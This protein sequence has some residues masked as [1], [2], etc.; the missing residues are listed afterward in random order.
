M[1]KS[2]NSGR[3]GDRSLVQIQLRR[4]QLRWGPCWYGRAPVKRTDTGSIPVTATRNGRASQWA[5]AAVSKTAEPPTSRVPGLVSSTLTPSASCALGRAAEVPAFQA[6]GTNLPSVAG[7]CP[8]QLPQ[9]TFAMQPIPGSSLLVVMVAAATVRRS[10]P[11]PELNNILR[12]RLTVG[13]DA[14]NV[15]MLVRFQ[16][17]QLERKSS[18]RMRTLS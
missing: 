13:P 11:T 1:G 16:L 9:G 3:R 18:G 6:G 17:P 12:D 15:L 14:L 4:L 7:R 10:I 5:M 2:G 8:V